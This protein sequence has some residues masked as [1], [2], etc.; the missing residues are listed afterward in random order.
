M[1][2]FNIKIKNNVEF[3]CDNYSTIFNAAE[4]SGLVLDHSCLNARCRSC[5]AKVLSGVTENVHD[6]NVLSSNE[7]NEG[8]VLTCNVRPQSDLVL[9]IED[10]SEYQIPKPRTIPAKIDSIEYLNSE[11]IRL[12]LRV[13]PKEKINFLS[14]QYVNLI[15]SSIKRSYSIANSASE[16]SNLEFLIK[17]YEG[18]VMSNYWFHQA[19]VN[20]LL[21][22][23]GP[24]G[25][26]FLRKSSKKN[27]VLLATGTGIA[28]VKAIL[29]SLPSNLDKE[30]YVFWGGRYLVDLFLELKFNSKVKFQAVL[31]REEQWFD[32]YRGYVQDALIESKID[33][34]DSQVYACGSNEMIN[35]ARNLLVK[36][37]LCASDFFSD[38]FVITN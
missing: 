16:S 36:H 33:L 17:K 12:K 25:S 4:I 8:F 26:F 23:E 24:K 9:D 35:S 29:E 27:L 13:P 5:V 22:L 30:V 14:G 6:E 1:T 38:A 20:D 37:G 31:S 3:I 18:G 19:K 2:S 15:K 7:R 10:L 21:R 34:E 32:G 28:P 11:V